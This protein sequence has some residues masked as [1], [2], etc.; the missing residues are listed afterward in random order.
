[1]GMEWHNRKRSTN[2]RFAR[3]NE[4]MIKAGEPDMVQLHIRLP[5]SLSIKLRTMAI[6]ERMEIAQLCADAIEVY[7]ED[8]EVE[9]ESAN[10]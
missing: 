5:K 8:W 7:I 1:M 6:A 9:K 2:G 4:A 3:R 10:G